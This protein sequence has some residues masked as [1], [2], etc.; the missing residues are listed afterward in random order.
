MTN[1]VLKVN[2]MLPD[3]GPAYERAERNSLLKPAIV[4]LFRVYRNGIQAQRLEDPDCRSLIERLVVIAA[5]WREDTGWASC[6]AG[7]LLNEMEGIGG[8]LTEKMKCFL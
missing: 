7:T 8:N 3:Q 4:I 1:L 2:G 5:F 6:L